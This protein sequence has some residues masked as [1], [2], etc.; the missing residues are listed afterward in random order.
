MLHFLKDFL[1]FI[2]SYLKL[3]FLRD[4]VFNG[5][6]TIRYWKWLFVWLLWNFWQMLEWYIKLL[7]L[8]AK[9]D[10]GWWVGVMSWRSHM[11]LKWNLWQSGKMQGRISKGTY[12]TQLRVMMWLINI[13]LLWIHYQIIIIYKQWIIFINNIFLLLSFIT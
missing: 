12:S 9:W 13:L 2:Y 8:W 7:F 4:W 11:L 5:E 1:S 6:I 3:V 10:I